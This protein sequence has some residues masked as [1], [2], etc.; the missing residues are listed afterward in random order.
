MTAEKSSKCL[1]QSSGVG[2]NDV[3]NIGEFGARPMIACCQRSS[4]AELTA[5]AVFRRGLL[6]AWRT[7]SIGPRSITTCALGRG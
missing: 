5:R 6:D 4:D 3:R 1:H 2:E 7:C